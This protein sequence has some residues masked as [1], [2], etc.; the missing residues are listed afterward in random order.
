MPPYTL[1]EIPQFMVIRFCKDI[2]WK[3]LGLRIPNA[4]SRRLPVAGLK[5]FHPKHWQGTARRDSNFES[6][7][8]ISLTD[9]GPDLC[10]HMGHIG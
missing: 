3:I 5:H 2:E 7:I 1:H 6:V 4:I 10:H 9:V 8:L